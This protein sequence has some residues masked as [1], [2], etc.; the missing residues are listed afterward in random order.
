MLKSAGTFV[1]LLAH[2]SLDDNP[3]G[4]AWPSHLLRQVAY[5]LM[6]E[7]PLLLIFAI[8]GFESIY[9]TCTVFV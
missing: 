2:N 7:W 1:H 9:C 5:C 4:P 3:Q 6:N 8:F